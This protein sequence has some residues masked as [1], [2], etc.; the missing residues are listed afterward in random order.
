MPTLR[1]RPGLL[2]H[3]T[4]EARRLRKPRRLLPLLESEQLRLRADVEGVVGEGGGGGDAFVEERSLVSGS[5]SFW[6]ISWRSS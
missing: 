3:H 4:F 5:G 1:D 2:R 6:R